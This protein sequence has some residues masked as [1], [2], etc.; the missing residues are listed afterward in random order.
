MP[1]LQ[2]RGGER[3]AGSHHGVRGDHD[4]LGVLCCVP[5]GTTGVEGRDLPH[6]GRIVWLVGSKPGSSPCGDTADKRCWCQSRG[7]TPWFPFPP[8]LTNMPPSDVWKMLCSDRLDIRTFLNH[9][10]LD[11]AG[12]L[13]ECCPRYLVDNLVVYLLEFVVS[14]TPRGMEREA[15]R[16]SSMLT[17]LRP[18]IQKRLPRY[19]LFR[20]RCVDV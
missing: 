20:P 7:L 3:E 18:I 19:N 16:R 6:F 4:R 17:T 2:R 8:P 1:M 10:T 12:R 9:L 14:G 5:L 13:I 15:M 11:A